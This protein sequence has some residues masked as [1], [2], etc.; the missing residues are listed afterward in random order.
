MAEEEKDGFVYPSFSPNEN[1]FVKDGQKVERKPIGNK[2]T[3][4]IFDD[5]DSGDYTFLYWNS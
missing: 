2:I 5:D 4:D 3:N 1:P